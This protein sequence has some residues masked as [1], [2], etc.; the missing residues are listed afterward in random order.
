[1]ALYDTV[2]P[3]WDPEAPI[4]SSEDG[5]QQKAIRDIQVP[6]AQQNHLPIKNVGYEIW[7]NYKDHCDRA[8][9]TMVYLRE[10]SPFMDSIQVI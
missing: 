5:N 4:E 3:I 6:Q 2:P 7:A 9:G 10:T 8:L 1:M